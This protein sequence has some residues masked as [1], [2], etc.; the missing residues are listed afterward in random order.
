MPDLAEYRSDIEAS[1]A[2]PFGEFSVHSCGPWCQGPVL[3][4]ML[5][6]VEATGCHKHPHNSFEYVHS[7]TEIMKLTFADRHAYYGDPKFVDVP[8]NRLMS[9]DY[10]AR[11]LRLL[12]APT[13]LG[14]RLPPAGLVG[15]VQP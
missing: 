3:G 2:V 1:V 8:L 11:T 6:L 5:R 7:L 4:Q 9:R 15:S 13:R 10:A 12:S 14:R